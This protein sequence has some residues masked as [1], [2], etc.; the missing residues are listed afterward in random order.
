MSIWKAHAPITKPVD[1]KY[2]SELN[3]PTM[4]RVVHAV[5]KNF[6]NMPAALAEEMWFF[7]WQYQYTHFVMQHAA[8]RFAFSCFDAAGR[9]NGHRKHGVSGSLILARSGGFRAMTTSK[10]RFTSFLALTKENAHASTVREHARSGCP[11]SG[12]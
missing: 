9:P 2:L 5:P 3:V 11:T 8:P 4:M 12:A 10:F 1:R 7:F 6:W